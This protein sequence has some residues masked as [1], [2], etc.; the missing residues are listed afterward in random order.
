MINQLCI[1]T[2]Q[3]MEVCIKNFQIQV[4][5]IR[6]GRASPELLNS[7]YIE[8]FGSKVSLRQISNIVVEDYHTLKIN[9]FDSANTSL[10]NKAILNSNL[11]LNPVIHGKDIIVPIPGLTEERRRSL[12]KIVRIN[13]EKNRIHIRNIRRDAN[14]QIK[15]Y[16]KNKIIG[17]DQEHSSQ[18][19]IQ[20][21]TDAYI[22]KIENILILKE[23]ELMEF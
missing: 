15:V 13:A 1:K 23:K 17:E 3:K 5:N 11:D 20:K 21:M 2:N 19:Q 18:N 14:E 7:I 10:V 6:T 12:I 9:I 22:K 8:Y 16:L 4:N